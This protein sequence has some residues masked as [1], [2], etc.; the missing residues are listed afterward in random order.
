[1]KD[2]WLDCLPGNL[3]IGLN[4]LKLV[5]VINPHIIEC[6]IHNTLNC[7]Y[8]ILSRCR[9]IAAIAIKAYKIRPFLKKKKT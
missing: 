3:K 1:M 2:K 4:A 7:S 6:D 8:R 5:S 9:E